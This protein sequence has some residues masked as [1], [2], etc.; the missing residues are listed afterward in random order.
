MNVSVAV[1]L[2]TLLG[3]DPLS[4]GARIPQAAGEG[5]RRPTARRAFP[6]VLTRT[7]LADGTVLKFFWA[8]NIEKILPETLKNSTGSNYFKWFIRRFF[9]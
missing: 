4:S 2:R 5:R 1:L 9:N 7:P 8:G 6:L 3:D